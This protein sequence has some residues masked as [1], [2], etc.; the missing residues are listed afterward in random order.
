MK[1]KA[2][3]WGSVSVL[4]S[5]IVGISAL[6]RNA[7]YVPMILLAFAT[8]GVWVVLV[9]CIPRWHAGHIKRQQAKAAKSVQEELKAADVPDLNVAQT[10]LRHV[11]Y[12]I[13]AYLQS[14]YP[15]AR[16]NGPPITLRFWQFREVS[17][18]SAFMA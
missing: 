12:R 8:W 6:V 5:V 4:I 14:S 10:L 13:T 3:L 7:L 9:L 2:T 11:N 17:A 16:W 18:V 1:R 15:N